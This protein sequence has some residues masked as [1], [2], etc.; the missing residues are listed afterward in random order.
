MSLGRHS[1]QNYAM[2]DDLVSEAIHRLHLP[3]IVAGGFAARRL[4]HT[5]HHNH[6]DIF[7]YV[8]PW[9]D[10]SSLPWRF[11]PCFPNVH[12]E[13]HVPEGLG[14]PQSSESNDPPHVSWSVKHYPV[15]EYSMLS[16]M[17]HCD[18][19]DAIEMSVVQCVISHSDHPHFR[20]LLHPFEKQVVFKFILLKAKSEEQCLK[21]YGDTSLMIHN[22]V[23][24]F[25]I[26]PC[27]C[28]GV[29][30]KR[31]VNEMPCLLKYENS[32]DMIY[33]RVSDIGVW[34]TQD[35]LLSWDIMWSHVK[36]GM[37]LYT[38]VYNMCLNGEIPWAINQVAA[39][40]HTYH[41]SLNRSQTERE[42]VKNIHVLSRGIA[43]LNDML[44]KYVWRTEVLMTSG[45]LNR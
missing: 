12:N 19:A 32:D 41:L 22:I 29:K 26:D 5:I 43:C 3:A 4:G 39:Y 37:E 6:I 31:P 34:P 23:N 42:R 15:N 36:E 35:H 17:V 27:K 8:P 24:G 7:V 9:F 44:H 18:S 21:L 38:H 13:R 20:L 30:W 2:I 45:V 14:W 25:D 11:G 16:M 40:I 10:S 28:F 1:H 33:M